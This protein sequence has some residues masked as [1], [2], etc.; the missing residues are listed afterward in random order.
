VIAPVLG[1]GRTRDVNRKPLPNTLAY[2]LGEI[3][4]LSGPEAA[5]ALE[6]SSDLFRKRLQHARTAIEPVTRR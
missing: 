2:V 4:D 6:I 1:I 3:F 5:R